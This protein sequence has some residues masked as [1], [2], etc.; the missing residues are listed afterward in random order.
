MEGQHNCLP[1]KFPTTSLPYC[2]VS[3]D[4][5]VASLSLQSLNFGW[6]FAGSKLSQTQW[7]CIVGAQAHRL[8]QINTSCTWKPKMGCAPTV[9]RSW[10][11][12]QRVA[13]DYTLLMLE[14][15]EES[16]EWPLCTFPRVC[17]LASRK[18]LLPSAVNC[19]C[20]VLLALHTINCSTRSWLHLRDSLEIEKC[21]T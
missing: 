16:A 12:L 19:R 7:G 6:S 15:A 3:P 1:Y 9:K 4:V 8:R 20:C 14:E 10:G 18:W 5:W 17:P 13:V 21:F 11:L 2:P